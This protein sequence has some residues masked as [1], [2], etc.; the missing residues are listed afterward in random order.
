MQT[1]NSPEPAKLSDRSQHL[2]S[3]EYLQVL[4]TLF[5]HEL[6]VYRR[7]VLPLPES[8]ELLFQLNVLHPNPLVSR[9]LKPERRNPLLLL[10]SPE[11]LLLLA[12]VL[13]SMVRGCRRPRRKPRQSKPRSESSR[14]T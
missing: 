5:Q 11:D 10:V 3:P 4:Q 12:V 8:F 14:G 7:P 1:S 2:E 9:P 13:F 6:T